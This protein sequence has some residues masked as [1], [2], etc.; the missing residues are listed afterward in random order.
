VEADLADPTTAARLFDL[1]E[2]Q[3]G[4]VDI[5][6]NNADP[7]IWSGGLALKRLVSA[8]PNRT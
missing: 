2:D 4:P 8:A 3:L 7:P 1:A 5:L 6:V